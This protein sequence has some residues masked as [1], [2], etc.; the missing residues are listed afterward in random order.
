MFATRTLYFASLV[1]VFSQTAYAA[2]CIREYTVKAGDI[3]DSIS[4]ANNASTYQLGA[5]NPGRI[6]AACT[7]LIPG[8]SICLGTEAE[9]CTQTLVVTPDLTCEQIYAASQI[10]ST[11]FAFNNP[12]VNAE[13]SNIYIGEVLCVAKE[14][15][16]PPVPEGAIHVGPVPTQTVTFA[17]GATSTPTESVSL[18]PGPVKTPEP[19]KA[20]AAAPANL[21]PAKPVEEDDEEDCEAEDDDEEG[22]CEDIEVVEGPGN[23]HLPFCDELE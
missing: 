15:I 21:A 16:V 1:A 18:T 8:S 2:K 19:T 20:P 5:I 9:D 6:N 23:E 17:N 14:V 7:N 4:A 11:I 12:Q 3:C 10:N 22:E 13:C